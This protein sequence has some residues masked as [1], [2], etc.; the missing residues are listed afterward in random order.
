MASPRYVMQGAEVQSCRSRFRSRAHCDM[1]FETY[2]QRCTD[3]SWQELY[4]PL[5][6][7]IYARSKQ[8]GMRIRSIW[9][10]DVAQEGQS[11]V[12]NEDSLGNDRM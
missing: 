8:N 12:I 9:M 6:E 2:N 1:A 4:E 11:S 10:A 3:Y 5:W 7:E